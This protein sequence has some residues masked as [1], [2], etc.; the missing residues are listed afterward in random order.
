MTSD[1]V[2]T[3]IWS[4]ALRYGEAA[5]AAE[6]AS[7]LEELGYAVLWVPDIGGDVF[8]AVERLLGATTTTTVATGILNIWMHT[9]EETAAGH[10]EM[11]ARHGGR[12]LVGLGVSHAP[13]IDRVK[14]PGTYQRPLEQMAR[15][16][17]GL[18][19]ADPPLAHTD[20][21][22]AA[23]GPKMVELARTRTAG[24]HPYLVTPQ[25]TR[26]ARDA[27]GADRLVACEQGV[28]L[29]TDPERARATAR[30]HLAGYLGLPNY[31]NNWRRLG[32]TDEDVA[33][34]GSD[35]LVDALVAWGNE[36]A[37][38]ARVQEHRDA[39]ADHVCVQVLTDDPRGFPR[40][41]WRALAPAL[42]Q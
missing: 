33:D 36:S 24:T 13:F 16:L 15:F 39:G 38:A 35:R 27:V 4:S 8:E 22:I 19:A 28:V 14:E 41:Q 34:G 37:I 6:A 40:D 20:R 26:A 10:A 11:T 9:P 2:G 42:I 5:E 7:E 18:D 3:G 21:V 12:F 32:Y 1:I 17:D 23:L 31:V 25:H 30:L 29:E